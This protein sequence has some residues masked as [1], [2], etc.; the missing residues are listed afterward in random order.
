MKINENL[1]IGYQKKNKQELKLAL[2]SLI[3]KIYCCFT[4]LAYIGKL[5]IVK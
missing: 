2:D 4:K 5:Q 1:S 3:K